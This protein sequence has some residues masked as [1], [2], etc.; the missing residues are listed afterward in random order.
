LNKKPRFILGLT[1]SIGM[2]KTTISKMFRDLGV[3]VWC[4]DTEVNKLYEKNG[5]ATKLFSKEFPSVVTEKGVDKNKLR[6]LIH[7]DA[8]ILKKIE[9]IVHPLLGDSKINFINSNKD[10]LF[11]IFD[12]PLLL[13]KNQEK[14]F[15]AV[16][17]ITASE[18][19]QKNRVLSRE[20]MVEKDFQLIK[21]NQ[22]NE[23]EKVKR[24]DYIINTDKSLQETKQ[25]VLL[26][27]NKIKEVLS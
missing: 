15:D 13:E 4:A 12:I 9:E 19:T 23:E 16:L 18:N 11:I 27:H 14:N 24:A 21:Q 17:V 26:I 20:N 25:D 10:F 6:N 2:G 7:Q 1:G 22:L 8:S 5:A 3:P